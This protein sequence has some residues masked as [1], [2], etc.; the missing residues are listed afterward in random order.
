MTCS[1]NVD[2]PGVV[3]KGSSEDATS[4]VFI[5]EEELPLVTWQHRNKHLFS[6]FR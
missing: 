4:A 5:S 1:L 2:P 3:F 6:P